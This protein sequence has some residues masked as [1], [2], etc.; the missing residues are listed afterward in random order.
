[1]AK[2][3]RAS[4]GVGGVGRF[5]YMR[6]THEESLACSTRDCCNRWPAQFARCCGLREEMPDSGDIGQVPV[7]SP[8]WSVDL[9]GR[10]DGPPPIWRILPHLPASQNTVWVP[11]PL[12]GSRNS[13][14]GS[15]G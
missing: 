15:L 5:R 3:E 9:R 7:S 11:Y 10:G 4:D 12:L 14:S 8:S 1:M 6:R 13:Q 2:G